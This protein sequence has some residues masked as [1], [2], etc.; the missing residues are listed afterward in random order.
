MP[1]ACCFGD[2]Q[3]AGHRVQRR[4]D[5]FEAGPPAT[6]GGGIENEQNAPWCGNHDSIEVLRKGRIELQPS[7]FV[8]AIG[9]V[10]TGP[11]GP[12]LRA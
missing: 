1:G 5:A 10:L 2:R 3:A 4:Y 11:E 8:A 9:I 12:T 6:P 7:L